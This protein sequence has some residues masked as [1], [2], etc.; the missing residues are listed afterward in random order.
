M[1][2]SVPALALCLIHVACIW[3][4]IFSASWI[5]VSDWAVVR[6]VECFL[7]AKALKKEATNR[8]SDLISSEEMNLLLRLDRIYVLSVT[9]LLILTCSS[10]S[11]RWQ[12]STALISTTAFNVVGFLYLAS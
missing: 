9:V 8:K 12:H 4:L 5:F 2:G 1:K 7:Q 11:M 3:L 10:L 6:H